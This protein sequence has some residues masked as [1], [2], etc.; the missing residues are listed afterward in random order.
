MSDNKQKTT[1]ALLP[2]SSIEIFA[3]SSETKDIADS[4]KGDW[5]FGRTT[6]QSREGSTDEAIKIYSESSSPDLVIIET[7]TIDQ[8]FIE[9]LQKLGET[10]TE[11][12]NAII[13]GPDNDI[14]LYRELKEMGVSDYYVHPV[15][16]ENIK[17]DIAT[18]LIESKGI[19]ASRIIAFIGAKGG[20]GTT[21]FAQA[22]SSGIANIRNQPCLILDCAGGRSYNSIALAKNEPSGTL[23][24]ALRAAEA[25]DEE[26]LN[27]LIVQGADNLHILSTGGE[28]ILSPAPEA[29]EF[30]KLLDMVSGRYANIVLD[31]GAGRG[32][33]ARTAIRK[34]SDVLLL[35]TPAVVSLR[36]ARTLMQ[37]ILALRGQEKQGVHYYINKLG[38]HPGFEVT[39]KDI[40]DAM[41]D[42]P[43]ACGLGYTP[44]FFGAYEFGEKS[45]QDDETGQKLMS[46]L[47]QLLYGKSNQSSNS[48]KTL[49]KSKKKN[50]GIGGFINKFTS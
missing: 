29:E 16:H 19:S 39:K 28:E 44:K 48:D 23:Q 36:S 21:T 11:G 17:N 45:F 14:Q 8:S 18:V 15:S 37:E 24:E 12:T 22:L 40:R 6:V 50:S 1:S 30:E 4:I 42:L 31:L 43:P 41:D 34:A 3:L 26:R 27:R 38:E 7:K 35:S 49:E 46:S 25:E 20:V 13:I 2:E 9:Q 10:C 33:V 32:A 47:L 5:R